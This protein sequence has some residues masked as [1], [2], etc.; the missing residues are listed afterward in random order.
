MGV[1]TYYRN[2]D[3]L[4]LP[5]VIP[6][7]QYYVLSE[8]IEKIEQWVDKNDLRYDSIITYPVHGSEEDFEN[9]KPQ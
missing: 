2:S 8:A 3:V 7:D 1:L 9:Q 4:I 6:V 5:I